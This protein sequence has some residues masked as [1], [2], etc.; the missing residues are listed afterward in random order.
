MPWTLGASPSARGVDAKKRS[1]RPQSI[2]AT[3]R[4]RM[5][6]GGRGSQRAM[7]VRGRGWREWIDGAKA[8]AVNE[9][10]RTT[11]QRRVTSPM[12]SFYEAME[13]W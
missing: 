8:A 5:A 11:T 4:R 9:G 2:S 3:W 10:Q 7:A 13:I 12:H 6:R 1:T